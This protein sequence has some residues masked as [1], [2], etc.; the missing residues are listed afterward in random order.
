MQ[1]AVLWMNGKN[2]DAVENERKLTKIYP[3]DWECWNGLGTAYSTIN[4]HEEALKNYEKAIK[5]KP[6]EDLPWFN[7]SCALSQ[8]NRVDDALDALFVA[9]SIEPENLLSLSKES[10]FDNIR[11]SERFKKYLSIQI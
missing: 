4:N 2:N 3:D 6:N 7:K 8:M 9:I 10:D 1:T 11:N 5:I